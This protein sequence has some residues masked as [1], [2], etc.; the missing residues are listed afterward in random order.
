MIPVEVQSWFIP[1]EIRAVC[2]SITSVTTAGEGG[3]AMR[4]GLRSNESSRRGCSLAGSTSLG[5][6][7]LAGVD[8]TTALATR[9]PVTA[10]GEE[11]GSLTD[12]HETKCDRSEMRHYLHTRFTLDARGASSSYRSSQLCFGSRSRAQLALHGRAST[13]II[14]FERRVMRVC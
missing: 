14:S 8:T 5:A 7:T 12:S 3:S 1:S 2:S 11:I 6:S 9:L 4:G 13:S 10:V